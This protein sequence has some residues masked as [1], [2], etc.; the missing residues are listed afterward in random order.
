MEKHTL[1]RLFDPERIWVLAAPGSPDVALVREAL[2]ERLVDGRAR[3]DELTPALLAASEPALRA[4]VVWLLMDIVRVPEVLPALGRWQLR[5]VIHSG[6]AADAAAVDRTLQLARDHRVRFLGPDTLGIQR[7]GRQLNLSLLGA[8]PPP[9]SVAFVAQSGALAA[10]TLD[11]ALDQG[12]GFSAVAT[13]GDQRDIDLAEILDFLA[14]DAATESIVMYLE[15]VREP[16]SFLSALR[17]VA[18]VKPVVVL[19]AGRHPATVVAAQTHSRALVGDDDVFDA[20]LRRAGAVRVRFFVQLFSAVKCLASRYRPTGRRLAVIANGGGPGVLAADWAAES[21]LKLA[22]LADATIVRLREQIPEASGGNPV[23]IGERAQAAAFADAVQTVMEDA[24]VDGVLALFAPKADRDPLVYAQALVTTRERYGKPLIACW[25][26]DRRVLES[27][28]LLAKARIPTFRTPE[29]AVDAFGNLAA[30]YRNQQLSWQTPKALA[31]GEPPDLDNA[32]LL[33]ADVAASGREM[34]SET[35][36][37]A[38]LA[39]F[40]IPVAHTVL[41]HT[42]QEATLI[43]QQL[44]FPVVLKISSPDIA[45]KSDVGGVMLDIRG[46]RQLQVAWQEMLEGVRR[47]APQARIDGMV[48]EPMIASRHGRE[49]YIGVVSDA[50]FGPVI[51]FGAGGRAVEVFADRAMELPPLNRFLAR[52]LIRR[53]RASRMLGEWRGAAA[54]SIDAIEA[55]LL[56]VSEMVCELPQIAEIDLNPMIVDDR[57][58]TVVD[59]RVVLKPGYRAPR[60]AYGHMAIMPYPVR[61]E[62]EL[63]LRDGS[64]CLLRAIRPE[65]AQAL[66]QFVRGMSQETR[67]FRFVAS[68]KELS[69]KQLARYTQIDYW[70]DMALIAEVPASAAAGNDAPA[71]GDGADA[72]PRQLVGVA[73]YMLNADMQTCEFAIAIG[74]D[75]QGKGLGRQLMQSLIEVAQSRQLTSMNGM[76]LAHNRKMA[77]L[78]QRLGFALRPD[79]E[80]GSMLLATRAL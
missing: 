75:W 28:A 49:L 47:R 78:M 29:P 50:L 10:S 31:E 39:A 55:T 43:A 69:P 62:R 26:G 71:A 79:P 5:L 17:A 37:K 24:D 64:A 77:K 9:G 48:V 58:V 1:S 51:L 72:A 42:P 23:D 66:Q 30:F 80:D 25:L 52:R 8:M 19:K 7:P 73:R 32:R 40:H 61:L 74:D 46:A 36:S 59:A 16:R 18:T 63:V 68:I 57:G 13:V 76:I 38:L 54:A 34:L 12:V 65:D 33:L 45:H 44:G 11:W 14:A 22:Q 53:S 3:L 20:A 27:R 70:R 6:D 35:E 2:A 4:D 67:Y 60:M 41:A 21:G 15:G 56:R